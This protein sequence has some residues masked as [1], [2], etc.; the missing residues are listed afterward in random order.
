MIFI[1]I[2]MRRCSSSKEDPAGRV[3][4]FGL[5]QFRVILTWPQSCS[6]HLCSHEPS[7]VLDLG[8][9]ACW[10]HWGIDGLKGGRH[11][12][13]QVYHADENLQD[14]RKRSLSLLN[15]LTSVSSVPRPMLGQCEWLKR[16][17]WYMREGG[18]TDMRYMRWAR[19]GFGS[20]GKWH[21]GWQLRE[22]QESDWQR[23]K[24]YSGKRVCI[25]G[26]G[27][28]LW[29]AKR[30]QNRHPAQRVEGDSVKSVIWTRNWLKK[31]AV[32]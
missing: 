15:D 13:R 4:T 12:L 25:L 6:C 16:P 9:G 17:G 1:C 28:A 10:L 20:L 23:V 2:P 31:K 32:S 8:F 18:K 24:C 30:Q 11:D 5:N 3:P 26:M 22:G 7:K 27:T 21:L 29:K 14:A 19:D